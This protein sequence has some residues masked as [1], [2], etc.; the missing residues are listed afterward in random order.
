MIL[1]NLFVKKNM[2]SKN[3]LNYCTHF[4]CKGCVFYRFGWET[5]KVL[6]MF[7]GHN[8]FRALSSKL[9]RYVEEK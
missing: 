5:A 7:K 1:I 8:K 4:G 9:G 3:V 2:T 6:R